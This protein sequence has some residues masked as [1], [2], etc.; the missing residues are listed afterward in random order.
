M[1]KTM[2]E[3]FDEKRD[4]TDNNLTVL[5]GLDTGEDKNFTHSMDELKALSEACNMEVLGSFIQSLKNP[6]PATYIGSGKMDEIATFVCEHDVAFCVFE[7]TLSPAQ[8]RNLQK[9]INAQIFDRTSLILEIFRRRAKSRESRL[10]VESAQLQYMMP[11]LIGLWASQ[12][13]QGG[14]SGSMS[15]KGEGEKQLELDRRMIKKRMNEL[16]KELKNIEHDRSVQRGRRNKGSLKLISLVGYTNSGKSTIMNRLIRMSGDN[17]SPE[18]E[19]FEQ[20][21]LFATLDTYVRR[22]SIPGKN[23]FLLSDTVG[24]IN[25]LPHQLVKAFHSTL[26]E[27]ADADLLIEVID[28]SDEHYKEEMETTSETLNELKLGAI[29]RI[30]VMNK[31]DKYMEEGTYPRIEGDR[32]YLSAYDEA[33]LN[34]LLQMIFER[35]FKDVKET[36]F[37]IPYTEGRIVNELNESTVVKETKYLPEGVSITAD[38]S[39]EVRGRYSEYIT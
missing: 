18:K 26:E 31:A 30:Q 20:N 29:P 37:L 6:D 10:Q 2:L 13:R 8:L 4:E 25:K 35:I 3:I 33:S 32:I 15:S 36:S 5:V 39:D 7:D 22:I 34:M 9:N 16:E 17:S 14:A 38:C 19:V 28:R 23:E 1:G 21:M 12:G 11:R 27:A 24:F